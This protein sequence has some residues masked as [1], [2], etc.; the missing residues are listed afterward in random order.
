[1][2][3]ARFRYLSTQ[4]VDEAVDALVQHGDEAKLLGGGQSLIPMMKLR[5][6]QPHLLVDVSR[7]ASLSRIHSTEDDIRI[8]AMVTESDLERSEAVA[9]FAPILVIRAE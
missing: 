2:Y 5:F 7:I 9:S 1:M 4:T 8:G 3:P 6:A